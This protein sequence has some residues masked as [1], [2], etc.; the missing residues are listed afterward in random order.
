MMSIGLYYHAKAAYEDGN[1]V[2]TDEEFDALE[3]KL[4]LTNPEILLSVGSAERSG[5]VPLPHPM[6]SLDQKHDQAELDRWTSKIKHKQFI[7][8]EK[9]DG[10]S[11]LIVY[12][13]GKFVDSFSRGDGINGANNSR[14]TINIPGIPKLFSNFTGTVRGEL[15]ITKKDWPTVKALAESK[16][17][18]TFANSR[19]FI[20]GFL[21]GSTGIRE[22]YPY[23][24]FVAFDMLE[25]SDG[26]YRYINSKSNDLQLLRAIGFTVPGHEV[27]P[28]LQYDY[29]DIQSEVHN[30]IQA[31]Q[32]ELDGV[33][34]EAN[35]MED[36]VVVT[37]TED[38]NPSHAIKIKP[39]SVA[40]VTTVTDVEWNI[41]KN[42]LLK[43]I[44]HIEPVQLSGVTVS[45]ASG[46]NARNILDKGIGPGAT[47]MV[48]RRGDVIPCV[49][50][51]LKP[52]EVILPVNAEWDT[53]QVELISNDGNLLVEM[54]ARRIEYFFSKLGVDHMGPA[55]VRAIMLC[56]VSSSVESVWSSREFYVNAIG[57][58]GGKVYDQLQRV[59][60]NVK[61]E[62]ILAALDDF[63]R[64]IGERK[65][66]SLFEHVNIHDFL[67]GNITKQQIIS[68]HGF[69]EKTADLILD[70][71]D[72]A[73]NNFHQIEN[74]LE[75]DI[76]KKEVV[77]GGKLSGKVICPTGVRFKGDLLEKIQQEGGVVVD[78]MTNLVNILVAKDPD[79][80]SSK[81]E[82]AKAK[83][84]QVIS[85]EQLVEML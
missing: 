52:V 62:L 9:I 40:V 22:I 10:N 15:V 43:P 14:H 20:A 19:N 18:R 3:R 31:S 65:L 2:L 21:N 84:I 68:I 77:Q 82:K 81:I 80:N 6:G 12:R 45:K 25:G 73:L 44:V 4:A 41:S 5:K 27:N 75:L 38:L 72:E 29:S 66:R 55:N 74:Y 36:R 28:G 39:V 56:G 46:Y 79:S 17:G 51:V 7:M 34:I 16:T 58:N 13:D 37:G 1:P 59:L 32:Y 53:N 83:G 54:T 57:A 63:G 11:C 50:S 23:I 69:E 42:G 8:M 64:G 47:V 30:C 35:A 78:S 24:K 49:E 67:D 61:P 76:S 60:S 71:L 48:S 85:L 33:V 70:N 26:S